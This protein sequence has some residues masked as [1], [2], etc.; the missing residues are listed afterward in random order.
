[1][2]HAQAGVTKYAEKSE[3]Y[4]GECAVEARA[5]LLCLGEFGSFAKKLKEV[6]DILDSPCFVHLYWLRTVRM[7]SKNNQLG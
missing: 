2:Q 1:M 4:L 7:T 6:L 5:L 3:Y